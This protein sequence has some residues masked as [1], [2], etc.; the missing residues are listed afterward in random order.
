[1]EEIWKPVPGFEGKYE[2]SN[3]GRIRSVMRVV[4]S[5]NGRAKHLKG[6]VLRPGR[7]P[8]GHLTVALSG[9]SHHAHILVLS[10]FVGPRPP[11]METRHLDGNPQNN[12]LSNLRWGSRADNTRD[13]KW[14]G[15]PTGTRKLTGE[16][17]REIKKRFAEGARVRDVCAY[18][19]IAESTAYKI[20]NGDLHG[21]A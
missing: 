19:G 4:M 10:A 21:D 12:H 15:G 11:G 5:K 17:A 7:R 20:K 1:M 8:C 13:R 6:R 14:H 9:K 3:H 18:F 2:V 16:R